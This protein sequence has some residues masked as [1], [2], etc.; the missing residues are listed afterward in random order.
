MNESASLAGFIDKWRRRWPEWTVVE[1]FMPA[2][3]REPAAAWFALLQEVHDAAWGGSDPTPGLAKLAWWQEELRGWSRG[4]R[5]HPLGEVL[6]KLDAPWDA[7][8]SSLSALPATR[9]P[10]SA[11]DDAS[12][13]Q[14]FASA[15]LACEAALFD[16]AAP[17]PPDEAVLVASARI[18]RALAQG[19]LPEATL[20]LQPPAAGTSMTRPRRLQQAALGERLRLHAAGAGKVRIPA[21]RL[22]LAGWR[23]ARVG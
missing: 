20:A 19:D 9:L 12:A 7:L 23:A 17:L 10:G 16:G 14:A 18:E 3:Q 8:A 1:V 6:Q 22:V 4:A 11:G 15:V 2:A 13:L 21:L 5:R